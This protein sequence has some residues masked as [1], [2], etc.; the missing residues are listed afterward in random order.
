MRMRLLAFVAAATSLSIT[1]NAATLLTV[2]LSVENQITIT[3][4]GEASSAT[5]SGGDTTGFYLEGIFGDIFTGPGVFGS[6]VSGN[7]TSAQNGSDGTP[8][9]FASGASL[10][11]GLN[12]WSYTD[13]PS[14]DFIE[15]ELAFVGS[16]TW[17][18]DPAN[19][20]YAALLSG[21]RF[22]DIYFA[23]DTADDIANATLIGQWEVAVIPVPAAVW[24]F[25]SALVGLGALRRR[26]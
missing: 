26:A 16:A 8:A 23:A 3:A 12:V 24:L 25:G 17:D 21:A 19:G 6:L 7:L 13:D 11:D 18:L 10:G 1:A 2:D 20:V 22:G 15:G 5:V 14:S 9:L 4:T